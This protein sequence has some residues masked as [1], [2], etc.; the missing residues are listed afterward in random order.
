MDYGKPAR[1]YERYEGR[2]THYG[3][4]PQRQPVSSGQQRARSQTRR[5]QAQRGRGYRGDSEQGGCYWSFDERR[6]PEP[7]RG[8]GR[9]HGPVDELQDRCNKAKG[10]DQHREQVALKAGARLAEID[11]QVTRLQK[12]R[13]E[14]RAACIKSNQ[15]ADESRA[16]WLDLQQQLDERSSTQHGRRPRAETA[17]DMDVEEPELGLESLTEQCWKFRDYKDPVI[18]KLLRH[19]GEAVRVKFQPPAAQPLSDTDAILVSL[20]GSPQGEA[21]F[22]EALIR[23]RLLVTPAEQDQAIAAAVRLYV[24]YTV[25]QQEAASKGGGKASAAAPAKHMPYNM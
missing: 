22:A 4:Q 11:A 25:Q 15:L 16:S 2:W 17:D 12:Q 6:R 10:L 23:A 7:Q 5:S 21:D 3:K 1:S 20:A 24:P 19:I 13:D 18:A 8:Q 9:K 14:L